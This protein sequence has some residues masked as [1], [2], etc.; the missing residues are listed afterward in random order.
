MPSGLLRQFTSMVSVPVQATWSR[1]M[2]P[3]PWPKWA[4]DRAIAPVETNSE[5]EGELLLMQKHMTSTSHP[6]IASA[7]KSSL[8]LIIDYILVNY[9]G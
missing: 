8:W 7:Y 6:V 9:L 5:I 2:A 1:R 4:R 3:V